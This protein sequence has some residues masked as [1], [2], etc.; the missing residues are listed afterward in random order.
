MAVPAMADDPVPPP[1]ATPTPIGAGT[2]V[3]ISGTSGD[4]P[5]V[6]CKWE[7]TT[8]GN[9]TAENGD[10]GH[11]VLGTQVY[12]PVSFGGTVPI[13]FWV[14]AH[15]N[16]LNDIST[17]Y[18]DVFHP[19]GYPEQMSWKFQVILS[20]YLGADIN[21]ITGAQ[22]NASIDAFNA[23]YLA[24]L[25]TMNPGYTTTDVTSEIAQGQAYLWTGSYVMDY[26]Q[27]FGGYKVVAGA[28]DTGPIALPTSVLFNWFQYLPVTAMEID[29]GVGGV[30]YGPI[31]SDGEVSGDN[32]FVGSSSVHPTLRNIGNTWFTVRIQQDD[33]GFGIDSGT[34]NWNVSYDARIGS[35][36]DQPLGGSGTPILY[37]PAYKVGT[38]TT[39]DPAGWH[40]LPGII[41]LCNTWKIDFSIHIVK[42]I[43]S[44]YG[45]V[46]W[47]QA[48]YAP[49]TGPNNPHPDSGIEGV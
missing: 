23:A 1:T 19:T 47:L 9:Y 3:T 34:G 18:V 29:F 49:F 7:T 27:P 5:V 42:A 32:H 40:N 37:L 30:S 31:T 11:A 15:D 13:V 16:P 12:P 25:V 21:A 14:V 26:H 2:G 28:L 8:V 46:M 10:V 20:P 36:T 35:L 44:S 6:K 39:P 43:W 22:A 41:N 24:G 17:V 4:E 48:L 45:G 33:M 38:R